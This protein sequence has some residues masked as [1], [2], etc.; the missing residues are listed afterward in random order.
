MIE[1]HIFELVKTNR[2]WKIKKKNHDIGKTEGS[3]LRGV[4]VSLAV[5]K[6]RRVGVYR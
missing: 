1:Q 3:A 5:T 4:H 2:K 6:S